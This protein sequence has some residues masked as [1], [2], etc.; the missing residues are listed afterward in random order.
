MENKLDIKEKIAAMEP[1]AVWSDAGDGM[2]RVPV[3]SF[4]TLAEK[5]RNEEGFDFLRSLTGMDWGEEGLGCVYHL[6]NTV[7]GENVVLSTADADRDNARVPSVHDLWKGANFNE[8][9]AYDFFGIRF[10]GHPDLRRLFL[11]DDWKGHPFRKDYDMSLNPLNMENEGNEDEAP[12]YEM[13]PDGGYILR[14]HPLFEDQEY[15]IN[16]G[17]QHPATHGVLRFRVS[18]EGETIKKIDVHSGYIH[19]GIE[20]LCESL[21]Y[22][23]TLALTDRLD[24]LGAMQNRHALCACIEKAMGLEVSDRIKCIR[25]I[26]DELQRIDSHLLFIACLSQDMGAL[27]VFF[28]G[29]RD[30]EKVLDILEQ[31]TGGRLIQTYNTIGGV[32]ADIHPDFVKKTKEFIRYMRPKMREYQEIFTDNVIVRKRLTGTGILSREDAISFGAT[33][34]SGRASGW[35]CDVRK[36]H[37]YAM[38][39]KVDFE[40]ITFTSGDC[41][42]RYM[43]RVKEIE[44]SL[45]IIEQLIDNI[46]EGEWQMKVKPVIKLPEG[47]WYTAVE[48]SRGEFGV[49]IE[50]RGDKFPYRVKFRSTGLPLVSCIDTISRNAKIADLIAIGG[51]LDYVVPDIDR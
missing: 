16:I 18:L 38:Y 8:R 26:M 39:D 21:T 1:S 13:T 41:F 37:P 9:E 10:V 22:P 36:R 51:T 50:S 28:L 34:G 29:F 46:P 40:E 7:T 33:G 47:S 3:S 5:L 4:R 23:Q 14:R 25:T 43:V 27:E 17:P 15:V 11:R 30:R 24:Y 6:E 19:R 42:D 49:F 45:N 20:K 31:T 2:F 35:A 48:G 32:Q 44:Q 12:S